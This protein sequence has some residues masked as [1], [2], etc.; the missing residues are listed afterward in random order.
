M[1]TKNSALLRMPPL[2]FRRQ[3]IRPLCES[4]KASLR[5][6]LRQTHSRTT[7]CVIS[8]VIT[9]IH[10]KSALVRQRETLLRKL[11]AWNSRFLSRIARHRKLHWVVIMKQLIY[12]KLL[13]SIDGLPFFFF[14]FFFVARLYIHA[15]KKIKCMGCA[16]R[17]I[18]KRL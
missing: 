3:T 15:E 5:P 6:Y 2:R 13:I 11:T 10:I 9:L 14:F 7:I 18:D 8:L 17:K 4:L 1:C 16:R 12:L